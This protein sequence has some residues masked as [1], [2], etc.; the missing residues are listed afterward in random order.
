MSEDLSAALLRIEA[1]QQTG[2]L[3]VGASEVWIEAGR[4]ALITSPNG[5]D[6]AS[7]LFAGGEGSLDEIASLL[8]TSS[9]VAG[10]LAGRNPEAGTV[11]GRLL[12]E[13]NLNA[14]FELLVP[15]DAQPS[16]VEGS[17]HAVGGHFSEPIGQLLDQAKRRLGI[18]GEIASRI[19]STSA[20][21]KLATELP[22]GAEERAITADE[23]RYLSLLDG[24]RTVADVITVTQDS[25]FRVCSSLYRML[26]EGIIE[27]D[28]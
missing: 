9:N 3:N 4:L 18:W 10:T 21:F 23:W 13:H 8:S 14:L 6:P 27:E 19:P 25:A 20:T 17:Q 24:R 11:I 1:D 2:V 16:F 12:H 26:L 5:A 22:D 15:S 28:A 7:V